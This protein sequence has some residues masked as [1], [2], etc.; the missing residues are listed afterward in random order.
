MITLND[1][2]SAEERK[3]SLFWTCFATKDNKN[4]F[5]T[6]EEFLFCYEETYGEGMVYLEGDDANNP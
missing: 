6:E 5:K 2:Q 3:G 1:I 4:P